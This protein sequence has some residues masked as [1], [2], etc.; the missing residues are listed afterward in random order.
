MICKNVEAL[1]SRG[2]R[3]YLVGWLSNDKNR[4]TLLKSLESTELESEIITMRQLCS[5]CKK[6]T[7]RIEQN[8]LQKLFNNEFF[9][10]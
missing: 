8:C 9:W 4:E 5:A 6:D 10:S 3:F 7:Q 2:S 1:E